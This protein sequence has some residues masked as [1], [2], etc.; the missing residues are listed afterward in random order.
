MVL[1]MKIFDIAPATKLGKI[2]T[3]FALDQTTTEFVRQRNTT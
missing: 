1:N 2:K 3:N